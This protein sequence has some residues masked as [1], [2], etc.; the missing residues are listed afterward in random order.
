MLG[1]VHTSVCCSLPF[2]FVT[3]EF[4]QDTHTGNTSHELVIFCDYLHFCDERSKLA[5]NEVNKVL[6]AI[7][8]NKRL[9]VGNQHAA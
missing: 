4:A 7:I 5:G 6:N 8:C 9:F 1:N 3:R 2:K